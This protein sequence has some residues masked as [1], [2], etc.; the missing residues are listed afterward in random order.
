MEDPS[1]DKNNNKFP[2]ISVII[3]AHDRKQFLM[4]AIKSVLNQ[5]LDKS[6]YEIIVIKN[7]KDDMIDNFIKNENIKSITNE[8]YTFIGE[9]LALGIEMCKGEVISF[10][11]D[12]D[13]FHKVKLENIY[14]LF[15]KY[16]DLVYYHNYQ[17]F[18]NEN[19]SNTKPIF[20]SFK[21]IYKSNDLINNLKKIIHYDYYGPLF[22]NMS[23]ISIRKDYF[24]DKLKILKM[25]NSH[26]DDFFFFYSLDYENNLLIFDD[27]PLTFYLVHESYS[28][29]YI[30]KSSQDVILKKERI[31]NEYIKTT[32]IL[33]SNIKND[34]LKKFLLCRLNKEQIQLYAV[35]K[36]EK[37]KK[38]NKLIRNRIKCINYVKGNLITRNIRLIKDLFLL[39]NIFKK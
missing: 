25:I 36:N 22:F 6:L 16:K 7:F 13:Q 5:T 31:Y 24:L 28:N 4:D 30:K 18:I 11:D 10:L 35:T 38:E 26:P 2:Y 12:D 15:K 23:S 29:I 32:N 14:N 20:K 9:D 17:N 33:I 3:T 19:K 27:K 1:K 21:G 8:N 34:A 37:L 39:L